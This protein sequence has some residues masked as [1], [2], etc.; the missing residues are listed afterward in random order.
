MTVRGFVGR[1]EESST[2][3]GDSTHRAPCCGTTKDAVIAPK[4]LITAY[5]KPLNP[6]QS[7]KVAAIKRTA[8]R[9]AKRSVPLGSQGTVANWASCRVNASCNRDFIVTSFPDSVACRSSVS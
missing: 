5:Q 6:G 8:K 3:C 2:N 1:H 7:L 9:T 4:R